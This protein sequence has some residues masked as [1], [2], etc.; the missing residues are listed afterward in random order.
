MPPQ[1]LGGYKLEENKGSNAQ[2]SREGN[3]DD[4][5]APSLN[6]PDLGNAEKKEPCYDF[7]AGKC[8]RGGDQCRFIHDAEERKY[9][10]VTKRAAP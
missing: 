5:L 10:P 2:D 1:S 7:S 6:N 9:V 3:H 8:N 4:G